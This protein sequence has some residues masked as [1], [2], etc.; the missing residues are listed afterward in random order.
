MHEVDFKADPGERILIQG[1]NGS[2]KSSLAHIISGLLEP[3]SGELTTF[4]LS[5]ISA[6]IQPLEFIPGSVRDNVSFAVS[7]KQKAT[8]ENLAGAFDIEQYLDKDPL[9]LSSGQRKKLEI[10]MGLTKEANIYI[11]DEP[12]AGIDVESKEKVMAQIMDNTEDKIL[13]VIMHGD[14][15]FHKF[16][17]RKIEMSADRLVTA[18]QSAQAFSF[19]SKAI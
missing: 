10:I 1:P 2:G 14:E 4:P 11:F 8:F 5:D 12:L 7:E 15:K 9:E 3:Q 13:V 16:F 17:D 6:I 19:V 18:S